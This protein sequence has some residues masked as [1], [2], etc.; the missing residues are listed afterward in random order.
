[1]LMHLTKDYLI[2]LTIVVAKKKEIVS[3]PHKYV[4]SL[5]LYNAYLFILYLA[6]MAPFCKGPVKTIT[7]NIIHAFLCLTD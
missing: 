1:M 3:E 6:T 7:I 5:F 2:K 4:I